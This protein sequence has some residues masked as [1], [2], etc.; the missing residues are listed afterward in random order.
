MILVGVV[1]GVGLVVGS[2]FIYQCYF[3]KRLVRKTW[4]F[5]G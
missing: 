4:K 3:K 5:N 1:L 2:F